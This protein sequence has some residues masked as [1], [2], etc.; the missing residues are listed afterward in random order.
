MSMQAEVA[1]PAISKAEYAKR[2]EERDVLSRHCE[3]LT[4][5]RDTFLVERDGLA[6]HVENLSTERDALT[7]QCDALAADR[8]MQVSLL[9]EAVAECEVQARL[10]GE[11]SAACDTLIAENEKLQ[12]ANTLAQ[13]TLAERTEE[14]AQVMADRDIIHA[15]AARFEDDARQ[16]RLDVARLMGVLDQQLRV[17][18]GQRTQDAQLIAELRA[19]HAN[20]RTRLTAD[21]TAHAAA[22]TKME[23][24]LQIERTRVQAL[25]V[26]CE[27]LATRL[28]EAEHAS[29]A[30]TAQ[31]NARSDWLRRVQLVLMQ[32]P[33]WWGLIPK[34][35]RATRR[36]AA[37]K[38]E[39]LFDAEAYRI[40]NP[41]VA[42]AGVDPLTHY[43]RI[44]MDE[45]REV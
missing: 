22:L 12:H 35:W 25:N 7:A 21:V 23:P 30:Q 11:A 28:A 34:R 40:R 24:A 3:A 2:V 33:A 27:Q 18:E 42:D 8:N 10:Y 44:G 38:R 45:R 15:R 32:Q 37:L 14:L 36:Y 39:N 19:E 9:D 4:L 26:Q 5:E 1:S 31:I 17:F 29:A 41:D 13:S 16:S 6:Q 20:V 43:I